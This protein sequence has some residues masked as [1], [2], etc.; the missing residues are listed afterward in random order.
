MLPLYC[1]SFKF[2]LQVG[3][4]IRIN[5]LIPCYLYYLSRSYFSLVCSGGTLLSRIE[6]KSRRLCPHS[7][8]VSLAGEVCLPGTSLPGHSNKQRRSLLTGDIIKVCKQPPRVCVFLC[9]VFLMIG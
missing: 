4:R 5:L 2:L 7:S 3:R 9:L 8:L 1:S 6:Q